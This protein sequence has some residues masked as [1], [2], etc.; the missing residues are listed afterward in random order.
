M[1]LKQFI[2]QEGGTTQAAA[3]LGIHFQTLYRW[4]RGT[5]K[6]RGLYLKKLESLGI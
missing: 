1:T 5:A 6:P 2:D 4:E 3:K